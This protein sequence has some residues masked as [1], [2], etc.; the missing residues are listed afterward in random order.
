MTPSMTPTYRIH[1]PV[2]VAIPTYRLNNLG[3]GWRGPEAGDAAYAIG[4]EV[5]ALSNYLQT[6]RGLSR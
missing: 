4:G 1:H 6:Q 5:I 3:S 2:H